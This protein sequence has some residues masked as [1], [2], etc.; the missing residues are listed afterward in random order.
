MKVRELKQIIN[1]FE[2]RTTYKKKENI[3][4]ILYKYINNNMNHIFQEFIMNL[5][6]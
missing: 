2:L 4:N 3:I 1:I 5:I 6:F